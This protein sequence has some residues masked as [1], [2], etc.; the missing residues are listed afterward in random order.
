ME[1]NKPTIIGSGISLLDEALKFGKSL[2]KLTENGLFSVISDFLNSATTEP[3]SID[4]F[5]S[6]YGDA[7]DALII[8]AKK[9]E[10]LNYISGILSINLVDEHQ[11]SCSIELYFQNTAKKWIVKK[12][13]SG[14][15][16]INEK[17]NIDAIH[18]LQS[19]KTIKIEVIEP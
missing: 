16:Q 19:Q 10:T 5:A 3:K 2:E 17:L 12:A 11:F 4:E 1:N 6:I 15:F 18:E 13:H 14:N 9:N 8:N 7:C